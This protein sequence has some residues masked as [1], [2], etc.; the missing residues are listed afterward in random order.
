MIDTLI[1]TKTLAELFGITS[2]FIGFYSLTLKNDKVLTIL[3]IFVNLL[4]IP[5]FLLLGYTSSAIVVSLI[6]LRIFFA[7]KY[8]SNLTYSIF[9]LIAIGQVIY[10]GMGAPNWY[11]FLPAIAGIVVT[12]VYFKL[13]G[14]PMRIGFIIACILWTTGCLFMGSYSVAIMNAIGGIL[15]LSTI[16]RL[17]RELSPLKTA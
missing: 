5:H 13:K 3:Q 14:I 8:N 1:T 16:I 2:A 15:N 7:Y 11:E 4:L 10:M 9:I 12:H 6:S 17:K